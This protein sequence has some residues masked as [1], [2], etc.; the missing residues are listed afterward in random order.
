MKA[1]R[2]EALLAEGRNPSV[3]ATAGL[4]QRRQVAGISQMSPIELR[5]QFPLRALTGTAS[6]ERFKRRSLSSGVRSHITC[7]LTIR[8]ENADGP[9][10][11]ATA[12]RRTRTLEARRTLVVLH[13]RGILRLRHA[14]AAQRPA[15]EQ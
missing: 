1:G 3:I 7:E 8:R 6:L 12:G 4:N 13:T 2:P 5:L 11:D 14:A 10:H 9:T 15:G